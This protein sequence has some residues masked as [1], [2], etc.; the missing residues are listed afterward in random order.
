VE[1]YAVLFRPTDQKENA[2]QYERIEN[3]APEQRY[4]EIPISGFSL[5]SDDATPR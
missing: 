5:R 2:M 1:S 3:G 4:A